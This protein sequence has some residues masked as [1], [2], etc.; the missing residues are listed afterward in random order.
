MKEKLVDV[1]A[2]GGGTEPGPPSNQAPTAGFNFSCTGLTC[3]FTDT[4]TDSDG[5]I[6]GWSWGFGDAATSTAQNPSRTYA[7]AGTY[8]VSLKVTDNAGATNTASRS[9][10]VSAPPPPAGSP[11]PSGLAL[12]ATGSLRYGKYH[13]VKL[14]WSGAGGS[15]V[16]VYR[17]GARVSITA[18]DGSDTHN[19]SGTGPATY[20][21][22]VCERTGSRC[23]NNSTVTF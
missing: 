7:A 5:S 22:K 16:D 2:D 12:T 18:N 23:S 10:T 11:P 19:L 4:S 8:T 1:A 20:T 21:Y 13:T 9:V 3:G 15:Y 6:T 17:N 14:A